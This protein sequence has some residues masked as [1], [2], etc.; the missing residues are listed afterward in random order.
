MAYK[1]FDNL[2]VV[3]PATAVPN[4]YQDTHMKQTSRTSEESERLYKI[5]DHYEKDYEEKS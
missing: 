4:N 5:L 3:K 1:Q 2:P